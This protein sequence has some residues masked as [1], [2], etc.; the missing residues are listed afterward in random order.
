MKVKQARL[1]QTIRG[2]TSNLLES[3]KY[4]LTFDKGMLTARL[5][6]NPKNFG[7]FIIFPANIAYIETESMEEAPV[8]AVQTPEKQIPATGASKKK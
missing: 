6:L 5:K 8:A 4:D 3:N 7:D 1:A 2:E